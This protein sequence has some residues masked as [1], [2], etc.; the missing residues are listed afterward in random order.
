MWSKTGLL[1]SVI[2][3]YFEVCSLLMIMRIDVRMWRV[4]IC[5]VVP[6]FVKY[7]ASPW[8]MGVVECDILTL[9]AYASFSWVIN[10]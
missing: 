5:D 1:L 2:V 6:W 4:S 10:V 8:F 3:L 9:K 7:G